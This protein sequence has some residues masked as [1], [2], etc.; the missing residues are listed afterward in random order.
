MLF[1]NKWKVATVLILFVLPFF[2]YQVRDG[3][4]E[5]DS[6]YFLNKVCDQDTTHWIEGYSSPPLSTFLFTHLPCND[7]LLKTLLFIAYG[8]SLLAIFFIGELVKKGSGWFVVLFSSLSPILLFASLHF[9]ND[10]FAYPMMFIGLYFFLRFLKFKEY[11]SLISCLGFLA[12][13]TF[14]WGGSLYYLVAFAFVFPPLF[15]L[16][17]PALSLDNFLL[18]QY[19]VPNLSVWPNI[20]L[21]EANSLYGLFF[22]SFYLIG[23]SRLKLFEWK[24]TLPILLLGL[25]YPKYLIFVVP[26]IG[27]TIYDHF[28]RSTE[29]MQR[30]T[31]VSALVII[32]AF[33]LTI[34]GLIA[35]QISPT[36]DNIE[37]IK[38][39]VNYSLE[40]DKR[41]VN[42]WDLGHIIIYYGGK[43]EQFAHMGTQIDLMD[44]NNAIVI[45]RLQEPSCPILLDGLTKVYEC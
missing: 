27:L 30:V 11:F 7:F 12:L 2:L 42:D 17:L 10:A 39:G 24:M 21:S 28:E 44:V 37:A 22:F 15:L 14:M 36:I 3:F 13:A 41:I 20:N 40:N 34:P 32:F 9:E 16:A 45:T 8:I 19:I 38:F 6:Y 26:L 1:E 5:Q 18:V 25:I 35:A 43:T 23:I 31:K 4:H 29:W 33:S